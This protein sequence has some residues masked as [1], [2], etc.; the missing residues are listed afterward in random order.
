[1][2]EKKYA[3]ISKALIKNNFLFFSGLCAV[4][5]LPRWIGAGARL[6]RGLVWGLDGPP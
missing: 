2:Q 6:A 3:Q 1:V 5:L 4:A